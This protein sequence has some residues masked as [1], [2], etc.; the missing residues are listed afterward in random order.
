MGDNFSDYIIF[1]DESGDHGL[2]NINE[3]YPIFVLT[4][5]IFKIDDYIKATTNL[6]KLKFKHFGH[7]TVVLHESEIRR[8][9]GEFKSLHK[10]IKNGFLN[11]LTDLMDNENFS[12]ISAVVDKYKID[13]LIY[14]LNSVNIYHDSMKYGLNK[15]VDF[16]KLKNN[17]KPYIVFE[18]RGKLEDRDLI[19]EFLSNGFDDY[20]KI[21]II[22][23]KSNEAG[24]QIADLI[25]RPIGLSVL[26]PSQKNRAVRAIEKKYCD[27]LVM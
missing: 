9:K 25:A 22:N 27:V 8:N 11:D 16:L 5:C 6:Q 24:L 19:T 20:F 12:T 17:K 2:K 18:S 10:K 21:K 7:D 13:N 14:P 26:R 23:K 1:A 3:N 4:F 15:L